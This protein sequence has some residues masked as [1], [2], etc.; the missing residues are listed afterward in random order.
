ML[1]M[2]ERVSSYL[3]GNLLFRGKAKNS[4]LKINS[5]FGPEKEN[6]R[7]RVVRSIFWR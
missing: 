2:T 7:D 5:I 3:F 6:W 4:F 1:L